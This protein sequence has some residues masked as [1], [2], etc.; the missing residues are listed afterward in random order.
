MIVDRIEASGLT[1]A[2][3][4]TIKCCSSNCMA[5]RWVSEPLLENQK[6]GY[7]GLAGKP[8]DVIF[9]EMRK[10]KDFMVSHLREISN[11]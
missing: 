10:A 8:S 2:N 6:L 5:W 9:D 11:L 1:C 4:Q 7:C 3:N